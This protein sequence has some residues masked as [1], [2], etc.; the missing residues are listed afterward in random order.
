MQN[1]RTLAH[2][3]AGEWQNGSHGQWKDDLNPSDATQVLARVPLGG[4]AEISRAAEAAHGA[5][6]LWRAKTGPERAELLYRAAEL[7]AARRQ[8]LGTVVAQEVGKP[9]GE[10]I[11]EVDRGVMI[12]RYFASEAV[13]PQG[14]V[15]PAQKAGSLQFTLRQPV[16][17]LAVISPWNFPVAIPLWKMAPALAYGNTVVWKPAETASYTAVH[18]AEVFAAAGFPAGVVNLLLGKGS[19]IG[20][21]LIN[22]EAIRGVTF[23]GSDGVGMGI[24]ALAAKRNIK[25][26]LEMGGKNAVIVLPDADLVQAAKLTAAGA[27]RFA[28]QKCTA[29]SR[30]IVAAEINDQF[31]DLLKKE[32]L[33]LPVAP[34]VDAK[35]AVGPVISDDSLEK[36]ALY[37]AKGADSGQ[38]VL[39]GQKPG[40]DSLSKG[41]FFE[42]TVI[43]NVS[44]DADVA[45]EEVF[46]PL[47]VLH[48]A[49]SVSEAISIANNSRYGLSVSLFTRDI[50]AALEYIQD[51]ECGMVRVNGDTTGVDPHAP[52]GGM[53]NSSSHSREQGPAAIEFFT[54]IKTVQINSTEA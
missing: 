5:F 6:A 26:Q 38:I 9:I 27:M 14:Q 19:T 42:P 35:S 1:I 37:A 7:L 49:H 36:V 22:H 28:G 11:P 51:I 16:G 17:P 31:I 50:S 32:I 10:A 25:F 40:T 54:E 24:A 43:A 4:P 3:I 47:L 13:H 29:T 2:Y 20:D 33:A 44:P 39:G 21:V 52:F 12:L 41:Y 46:G 48:E 30:A 23:T 34:A 18:L 45:Q 15:I 8:E 53:H